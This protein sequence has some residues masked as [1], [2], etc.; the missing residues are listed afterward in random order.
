MGLVRGVAIV[1]DNWWHGQQARKKLKVTWDEGATATQSSAGFAAKAAELSKQP[2]QRNVRKDGDVD[3]ALKGAAKTVEAAYSYP[4]IAHAPLEPQ[5]TTAQFKDG[6]I[7]IWSPTQ[8]PP[9]ARPRREHAR[10]S[11][12]N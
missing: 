10:S 5:N 3:A 8:N 4:F 11:R 7:E 9:A 2:P 1:A 6:K 12:P